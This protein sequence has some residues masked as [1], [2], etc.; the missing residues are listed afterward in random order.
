MK[1]PRE[2]PLRHLEEACDLVSDL[3]QCAKRAEPATKTTTAPEQQGHSNRCPQNEYQW[4]HQ[5]GIPT[6]TRDQRRT[7]RHQVHHR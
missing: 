3:L 5:E 6:E 4:V 1:A 2:C 7:K